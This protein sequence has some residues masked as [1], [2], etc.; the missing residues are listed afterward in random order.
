MDMEDHAAGVVAE[1]GIGMSG[2]VVEE[3]GDR[4][5]GGFGA[6]V[7]L[8][9]ERAESD[10]HGAVDGAGVVEEGANNVLE[11]CERFRVEAGGRVGVRS[12]LDG[13][14]VGGRVPVMRRVVG[15]CGGRVKKLVDGVGDIAGHGEIDGAGGVVPFE[16]ETAVEGALPVGGGGVFGVESVDEMLG[17]LGTNVLDAEVVDDKSEG[18]GPSGVAEETRCVSSGGVAVKGEV[19][20]EAVVCK[21]AG[22]GKA[23]HAFADLNHD[24][25]VVDEVGEFV[26]FHDVGGDVLH[27]DPHVLVLFHGRA[28]VE[29]FDVDGHVAGAG[30]RDDAV[31]MEFDGGEVGSGSRDL[32]VVDDFVA[33]D[34][35]SDAVR[36]GLVGFEFGDDAK[37]GGDAIEGFVGVLDEV[38]GVGTG[39]RSGEEALGEAADF[40][41]GSVHPFGAVGALE[42]VGVFEDGAGVGVDDGEGEVGDDGV[43]GE[44]DSA[45]VVEGVWLGGVGDNQLWVGRENSG[46][47]DAVGARA[48]ARE[49]AGCGPG[50]MRIGVAEEGGRW[51]WRLGRVGAS[52]RGEGFGL[53]AGLAAALAGIAGGVLV[54]DW[55]SEVRWRSGEWLHPRNWGS[56]GR[57][58]DEWSGGGGCG[59]RWRCLGDGGEDVGKLL[60]GG[61][62]RES[63][64]REGGGVGRLKEGGDEILGGCGGEFEGG[65]SGH[66]DVGREPG[67]GVGNALG[68]GCVGPDGVAA[69]VVGG[70]ADIPS[71]DGM[72]R[73]GVA[74]G[75]GLVDEDTSAWGR[76]RR[77]I[78]VEGAVNLRP[79]GKLGVDAGGAEEVEREKGLWEEAIPEM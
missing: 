51:R 12:V 8:G 59:D 44:A 50:G 11:M 76:K 45:G 34:G 13:G 19:F 35:E 38:H 7:L 37:V 20:L 17:M 15:T 5:G 42:E 28:E 23:V 54:G 39:E 43:V 32:A 66:V 58:A 61:A 21:D 16:V 2:R 1:G 74:D 36:V 47:D 10:E 4:N 57:R 9:G 55:W 22:L 64:R 30:S 46:F 62:L 67:E 56:V 24:L 75:G 27:W 60:E 6:V 48:R 71:F 18:D 31:E 70:G 40:E 72:R 33:A 14:A 79:G 52:E 63:S 53:F 77:S 68:G 69:V 65:G 29:V 26:L 25:V 73:P 49:I 41:G 3:L 78:E